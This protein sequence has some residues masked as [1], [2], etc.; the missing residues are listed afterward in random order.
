MWTCTKTHTLA[1]NNDKGHLKI[2]KRKAKTHCEFRNHQFFV[3]IPGTQLIET[4]FD[5]HLAIE[6]FIG[7]L[8]FDIVENDL[9]KMYC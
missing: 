9:A 8:V 5:K 7:I 6:L 1:G 2:G 4:S 3:L